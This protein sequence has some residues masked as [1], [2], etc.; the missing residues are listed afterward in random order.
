[1]SFHVEPLTPARWS[2]LEAVFAG[3]GCSQARGCW[4]MAY[5]AS[6]TPAE[7]PAG[8]SRSR[9]NRDALRARVDSGVVPGLVGYRDGAPVGWVAVGPRELFARLRRSPVMKPVDERPVWSIVCFVV[10]APY[11]G[12][13]V[14]AALLRGALD[15]ARAQGAT[16]VE[17]YPVDTGEREPPE[18][19]WFGVRTMFEAAGF[20]EVAR[21]KPRRP[22]VR[23]TL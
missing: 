5:L 20:T 12:Q 16:T 6:G 23:K 11:R 4:C 9:A 3:R 17:A 18:N 14:A 15:Y 13:G 2:D 22:V 8:V 19:L 1:L 21:R 7:P 10:P